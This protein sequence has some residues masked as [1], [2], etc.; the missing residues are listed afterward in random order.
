M[1]QDI[2]F[3]E[4]FLKE[5]LVAEEGRLTALELF[6]NALKGKILSE[7]TLGRFTPLLNGKEPLISIPGEAKEEQFPVV[8]MVKKS[9]RPAKGD[10]GNSLL[11]HDPTASWS[12]I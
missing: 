8:G 9:F 12:T 5:A 6:T 2:L 4:L 11:T 3:S 7:S 10:L 1:A